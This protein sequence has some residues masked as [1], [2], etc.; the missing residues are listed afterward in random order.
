LGIKIKNKLEL[1]QIKDIIL[2]T[3]KFLALIFW[4]AASLIFAQYNEQINS[5]VVCHSELDPPLST[6]VEQLK[7]SVHS[8]A[9]INCTGCHGGDASQE[10][11][12]LSMS[13]NKGFIG[14]PDI[15]EIPK[16]C[17]KC[18]SD[19]LYMRNF[20]PNISVEQYDRYKTS[21]H[22]ILLAKGDKK[23]ATC[24]S[25]HSVH[26]IKRADDPTSHVFPTNLAD[27]CGQC[28]SDPEYMK[29]YS[30]STDQLDEYKSSVHAK[31]LYEKGD[32]SAPTCNDCH[33]NHGAIPPGVTSISNVCG[34]CHLVQSE[35][36][37]TSPHKSAFDDLG[38]SE[39]EACHGNHSIQ[40]A[41]DNMLGITE[42]A[43]CME[44]HDEDSEG[45]N[46]AATMR[47][48]LNTLVYKI[49]NAEMMLHK[50]QRAGVEIRDESLSLTNARDALVHSRTLIHTF[51][52][53][54]VKENADTGLEAAE[55]ALSIG[56]E[57]LKEVGH[58]RF[59][60]II[61][62]FLTLLVAGL[63]VLYI[64]STEKKS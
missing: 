35:Y 63:L 14:K 22:G 24:T 16:F 42:G 12:E 55:K 58:R 57:A 11:P 50:A 4:L 7:N 36:F 21:R 2:I 6:P 52:L 31:M 20:N 59:M 45:Y 29:E 61:M 26:D 48:L 43:V 5:C 60:L 64:R 28:H 47:S 18:H 54:K 25:C 46:V 1:K 34:V 23:A 56:E 17:A 41:S 49:N 32:L 3:R 19:A 10:D 38:L 33:G 51:S 37:S 53:D 9:Q 27:L 44:C 62:V 15:L 30:I 13:A 40:P 39:C 8:Q